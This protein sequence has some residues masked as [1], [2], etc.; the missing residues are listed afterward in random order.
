MA[1]RY[2]RDERTI[3]L[4]VIQANQDIATSDALKIAM[5]LDKNGERS[6]AV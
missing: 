5:Q 6:L 2:C 4:I 3:I 1:V